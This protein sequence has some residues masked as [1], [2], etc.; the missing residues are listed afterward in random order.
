MWRSV[1][2]EHDELDADEA[3][4]AVGLQFVDQRLGFARLE[5]AS[6]TR[7]GKM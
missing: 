1:G 6:G 2:G 3:H 7:P 4:A 5:H